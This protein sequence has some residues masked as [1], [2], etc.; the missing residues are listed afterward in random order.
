MC[1][2]N[3]IFAYHG[4]AN[5]PKERELLATR[6]AMH[7]RGPDGCGIWWSAD[8]RCGLGHR[9]LSILDLSDRASQPMSS[10]DGRL[11][12]ILNGEIY[13]YPTLR[14]ELEAEGIQFRTS[15]DTLV[16]RTGEV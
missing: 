12:V 2:L 6:D 11:V 8:R 5:L 9:R 14:T 7:L 4:A 3:G 15:S 1:G 16:D 10:A 13:N